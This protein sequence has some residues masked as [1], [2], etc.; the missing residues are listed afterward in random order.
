MITPGELPK[1]PVLGKPHKA[2]PFSC[3]MEKIAFDTS[4][5][6]QEIATGFDPI[7]PQHL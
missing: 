5:C 6:C 4:L 3:P 1:T 2:Q 7:S